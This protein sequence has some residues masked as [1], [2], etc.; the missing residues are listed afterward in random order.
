MEQNIFQV[1]NVS[2][3]EEILS[4]HIKDLVVVMLSSRTCPPCVPMKS[5]FIELS[6]KNKD[7]F[8]VFIDKSNYDFGK[9]DKYFSEF[10]AFPTFLFFFG[11]NRLGFFSGTNEQSLISTILS[12]KHKI[13]ER[14]L[15]FDK[16]QEDEKRLAEEHIKKE[17]EEL[18][19][20]KRQQNEVF[21]KLQEKE[22]QLNAH[23]ELERSD[24][25]NH[26]QMQ[27]MQQ[28]QQEQIQQEQYDVNQNNFK[29]GI[30]NPDESVILLQ[31]KIT[32]LNKI[33]ELVQC[34]AKLT[35]PYNIESDY[36]DILFEI[37]F[38]T[39]LE[40]RRYVLDNTTIS[41]NL[42]Q[43][44]TVISEEDKQMLKKQEQVKQIR[45]LEMLN[46]QMQTQSLNKLQQLRKIKELK[47]GVQSDKPK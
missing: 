7:T 34:G 12:L 17:Q 21:K 43:N 9:S 28:I 6:K 47:D 11:E 8:F 10:A 23:R 41:N 5:K 37:R 22:N 31:K 44:N 46:Y 30:G 35:Q 36:E 27:Q 2:H 32:G 39:D 29:N 16:Q 15:Q 14:K 19:A 42:G 13:T 3:F 1:I 45:E 26:E 18:E 33:R 24:Q 4:N 20:K 38:H 25:V 40:F